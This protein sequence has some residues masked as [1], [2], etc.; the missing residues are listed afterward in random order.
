M[1]GTNDVS[2]G[3][4]PES[5]EGDLRK[6]VNKC[7]SAHCVP[8]LNTI[9]PRR[10]KEEAV[11][12]VNAIIRGVAKEASIPMVDYHAACLLLR[13]GNSWDGTLV[14]GDGVHPTGGK[15]NDYS[16]DNLKICGYALR[17]WMNFMAVRELVFRV[18]EAE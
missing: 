5:Y 2:A 1:I 16:A 8:I 7:L 17:N 14:S 11:E 18:L 6:I 3:H 12:A 15:T 13:P 4:V 9:P 10:G